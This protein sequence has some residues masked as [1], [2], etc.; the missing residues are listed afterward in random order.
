MVKKERSYSPDLEEVRNIIRRGLRGYQTQLYL[1]GSWAT[2]T[3]GRASDIDVAALSPQPIPRDLLAGIRQDLE[4]SRVIY[5]VDLVDL[6]ECS[7][8][9]RERVLG[10]AIPWSD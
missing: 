1:F 10:E 5:P 8:S 7:E 6:S 9:F 4:E 3:A 2:G